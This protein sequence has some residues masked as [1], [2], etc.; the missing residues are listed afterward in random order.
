[1]QWI[2]YILIYILLLFI[3]KNLLQLISIKDVTPDLILI[4]VIIISLKEKRSSATLIGFGAGLFQDLFTAGFFGLSAMT[5]SIIGFWGTFFQ[6]SRKKYNLTYFT[7][8]VFVLVFIHEIIYR[9]IYN[10]GSHIS[11]FR[12]IFH[13]IIPRTL[14]T[15]SFGIIIYLIYK[16]MFW[17]SESI[18]D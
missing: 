1:M 9:S 14:Y 16:P 12:L 18:T 11:L 2:K 3:E 10:L 15:L 4:F 6:Q 17:K 5:K 7:V 13:Y 8:A